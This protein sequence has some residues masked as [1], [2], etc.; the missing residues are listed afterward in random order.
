MRAIHRVLAGEDGPGRRALPVGELLHPVP[1]A[2]VLVLVVNDRW[3]KGAGLLPGAVTGKLSDVAGLLFF[4]LLVTAGT[5]LVLLAAARLGAPVDFTLRRWKLA[6]ALLATAAGFIAVKLSP[7]VAGHVADLLPVPSRIVADP[8]DLAALPM[9]LVAGWLGWR[10]IGRVPLGRI[11]WLQRRGG[12][13]AQGLADVT[14][15]GARADDV[16]ALAAALDA[17]FGGGEAAPAAAALRSIRVPTAA[18]AGPPPAPPSERTRTR[19]P[20]AG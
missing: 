17:Y 9:L 10:E 18:P 1:L 16:A 12:G 4:P 2:A 5:D 15:C 11:E 6:I 13:S 19:H 20:T 14:A 7:A 8:R 3:L